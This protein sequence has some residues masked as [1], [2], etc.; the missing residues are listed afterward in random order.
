MTDEEAGL[1]LPPR[2]YPAI[3]EALAKAARDR[4]LGLQSCAEDFDLEGFG[5]GRG[6]CIDGA[7]VREVCGKDLEPGRDRGQR[8]ACLC[9]KSVDIGGYGPCPAACAY[10]YARR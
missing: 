1:R 9:A 3:L 7:L 10:C 2:P 5:I 8:P 4:G 6:A